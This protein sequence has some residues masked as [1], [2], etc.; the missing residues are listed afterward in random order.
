MKKKVLSLFLALLVACSLSGIAYAAE[1]DEI[2]VNPMAAPN[3]AEIIL[4]KEGIDPN[5]SIGIG[6]TKVHLNLISKVANH[7]GKQA[8]FDG[9]KMSVIE[10]GVEVC[11]PDY[12][13]AVFDFLNGYGCNLTYTLDDYIKDLGGGDTNPALP[14]TSNWLV[15]VDIGGFTLS[16]NIVMNADGS[17]IS[18]TIIQNFNTNPITNT[19]SGTLVGQ[20]FSG[21]WVSGDDPSY[22]G[23][24]QWTFNA[25]FDGIESGYF[26]ALN[27]SGNPNAYPLGPI[28]YSQKVS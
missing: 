17:T 16:Y 21:T 13:Q 6:N 9:F 7:M 14:A 8:M 4:D 10:N 23:A 25:T 19:F 28:I 12:W 26:W 5:Q 18:G 2:I 22:V 15:H 11:N 20:N 27:N 1:S 3:I 24:L